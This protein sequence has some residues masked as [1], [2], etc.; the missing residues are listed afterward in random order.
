MADFDIK[1]DSAI[2]FGY[3]SIW[4]AVKNAEINSLKKL[5]SEYYDHQISFFDSNW[6]SGLRAVINDFSGFITPSVNGWTILL[7]N[8]LQDVSDEKTRDLL[9]KLSAHFGEAHFYGNHRVSGY[10]A[11]GLYRNSTCIRAFSFADGEV[12][13]QF[14]STTEIEQQII[15]EVYQKEQEDKEMLAY[16]QSLD[17]LPIFGHDENILK[18]A[19]A[20]SVNPLK[21][22]EYHAEGLGVVYC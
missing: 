20:W 13:Y 14:G 16:Y 12:L 22:D 17:N 19:Q 11:V 8:N 7:D 2:P 15:T 10:G 9:L 6:E 1:P 3:K 18:I 21:I 4:I 5:L